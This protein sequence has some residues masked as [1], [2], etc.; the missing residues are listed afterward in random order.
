M[1]G[2]ELVAIDPETILA[3]R[4]FQGVEQ[5]G[6]PSLADFCDVRLMETLGYRSFLLSD[7]ICLRRFAEAAAIAHAVLRQPLGGAENIRANLL[8]ML[9]EA[10]LECRDL[11]GAFAALNELKDLVTKMA[12]EAWDAIVT[13]FQ[14]AINFF[15]DLWQSFGLPAI[16][17]IKKKAAAVCEWVQG[18]GRSIWHLLLQAREA[19]GSAWDA[20]KGFLGLNADETGEEGLIQWAQRKAGEIWEAVSYTHLPLPTSDLV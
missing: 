15:T 16:E 1:L 13:F 11:S 8:L 18:I 9:V 2:E 4:V 14:P 3:S 19:L 12:G 5:K 7:G 17:W 20:I 6:T 10:R